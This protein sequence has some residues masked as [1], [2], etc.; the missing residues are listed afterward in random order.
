MSEQ[1]PNLQ[2]DPLQ[3][4]GARRNMGRRA[5]VTAN[6]YTSEPSA[7]VPAARRR[8]SILLSIQPALRLTATGAS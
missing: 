7:R 1:S 3:I 5:Y 2:G 8:T 6:P 4:G